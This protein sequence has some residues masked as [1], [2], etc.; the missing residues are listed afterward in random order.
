MILLRTGIISS[1][2]KKLTAEQQITK[3][4]STI[5]EATISEETA[6]MDFTDG[7]VADGIYNDF[8]A[9]WPLVGNSID[10]KRFNL[11]DPADDPS[12]FR[13][14]WG[15]VIPLNHAKGIQM[16]GGSGIL[17]SIDPSLMSGALTSGAGA[18]V[19]DT[20]H[21]YFFGSDVAGYIYTIGFGDIGKV[22]VNIFGQSNGV[23]HAP[24]SGLLYG[25][26]VNGTT[27]K[28][29]Q[30]DTELTSETVAINNVPSCN[31]YVSASGT[32]VASSFF[33][34]NTVWDATKRTAF[35]NRM[36]TLMTALGRNV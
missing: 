9:F 26:R 3:N 18:Y 20:N 34:L 2:R 4:Y 19:Q 12:S 23:T 17:T 15:S 24:V 36:N 31:L 30:G 7:L 13:L 11:I 1:S 29:Y 27:V 33:V 5:S 35:K 22:W 25:V 8:I 14:T 10:N 28:S 32:Y 6:L 16:Q 21:Q